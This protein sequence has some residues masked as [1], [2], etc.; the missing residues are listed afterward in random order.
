MRRCSLLWFKGKIYACVESPFQVLYVG[1]GLVGEAMWK[2]PVSGETDKRC[3]NCAI[4]QLGR[5][6]K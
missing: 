2:S 1:L 5:A 3:R 6:V 4:S